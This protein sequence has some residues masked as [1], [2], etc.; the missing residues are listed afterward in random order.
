MKLPIDKSTLS[1]ALVA[2]LVSGCASGSGSSG[3]SNAGGGY[4]KPSSSSVLRT[5]RETVLANGLRI[6]FV[7]DQ[8]LPSLSMGLMVKSGAS[9][10]PEGMAGLTNLVASLLDQGTRKR[11]ALQI[12]DDLG[13]IGAS[14]RSTVDHDY[15]YMSISGLS[16]TSAD[17]FSNF[18]EITTA[19]SFADAE[20]ARVKK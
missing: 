2:V 20:L 4:T 6:L 16:T 10:D 11:S 7:P 18:F 14:F 1:A 19:P 13:R 8:S 9:E 15:S 5:H 3:G 12:G 17:L